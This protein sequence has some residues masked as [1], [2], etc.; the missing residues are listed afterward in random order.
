VE[1]LQ[2]FHWSLS[3]VSSPPASPEGEVDGGQA[4]R[5]PPGERNLRGEIQV[6]QGG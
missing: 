4:S 6:Y 2:I 3:S 1:C 5:R